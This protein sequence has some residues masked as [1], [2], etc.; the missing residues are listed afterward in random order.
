MNILDDDCIK[1]YNNKNINPITR[2]KIK[3]N[4][5]IYKKYL[6]KCN[7]DITSKKL[8]SIDKNKLI[9]EKERKEDYSNIMK[10]FHKIKL[11]SD[12]CINLTKTHGKYIINNDI[13]LYQR[14]GSESSYGVIYKAKNNNKDFNNIPNFV[15]KLQLMSNALKVELNILNKLVI[16]QKK[17]L[18]PIFPLIY[19]TT[20][21]KIGVKDLN[22]PSVIVSKG[23]SNIPYSMIL[24]EIGICD[25]TQLL[26][27][28]TKFSEKEWKNCYEQMWM[29]IL[30][31]HNLFNVLHRDTRAD[32]FIYRKI[33]P[34]GCFCYIINGTSYYIENLGNV[35]MLWDFAVSKKLNKSNSSWLL[36]YS[37]IH[38]ATNNYNKII[39]LSKEYKNS[40]FFSNDAIFL[41]NSST[42]SDDEPKSKII[43]GYLNKSVKVPPSIVELQNKLGD[44]IY[45]RGFLQTKCTEFEWFKILLDNN[46]LF[47]KIPI[48]NVISTHTFF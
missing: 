21:C 47:S 32:N 5:P 44:H 1:W 48:G 14:I 46:I 9:T 16:I 2:K 18:I 31:Y 7:N 6:K 24:Y 13:L 4:G 41:Q 28:N 35:F 12:D 11:N 20:I 3:T 30:L 17:H 39:M 19:F 8:S 43:R 40:A 37:F 27:N 26:N 33:K 15:I 34:G 25:L 45:Y 38:S 23:N 36:D 10:Y 29:S 42:V 22:Y